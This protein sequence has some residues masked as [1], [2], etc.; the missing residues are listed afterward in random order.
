MSVNVSSSVGI[1]L[2]KHGVVAFNAQ[3]GP[4]GDGSERIPSRVGMDG[5]EGPIYLPGG[6]GNS[7]RVQHLFVGRLHGYTKF[8]DFDPVYDAVRFPP[9]PRCEVL[10]SLT[11]CNF[12][13]SEWVI[14][15]DATHGKSKTYR[16]ARDRSGA[17]E[18]CTIQK[19]NR[20]RSSI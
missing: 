17:G 16:R 8:Y 6:M 13:G 19:G 15:E 11:D 2:R 4:T 10:Q 7:P 20:C 18:N 3:M 9:S 1:Q 12:V 14:R 5:W